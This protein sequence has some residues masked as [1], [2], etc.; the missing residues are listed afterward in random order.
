MT[1]ERLTEQW[2]GRLQTLRV[3]PGGAPNHATGANPHLRSVPRTH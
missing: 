1:C 2:V 3:L